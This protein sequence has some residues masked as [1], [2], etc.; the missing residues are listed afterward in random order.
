MSL[1]RSQNSKVPKFSNVS[2]SVSK[3]PE[4][5]KVKKVFSGTGSSQEFI[6]RSSSILFELKCNIQGVLPLN[7]M[8]LHLQ[9]KQSSEDYLCINQQL[10]VVRY[11][12]KNK[13]MEREIVFLFSSLYTLGI[14]SVF[15]GKCSDRF[16]WS[17]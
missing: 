11:C 17:M 13:C 6:S 15:L 9:G 16:K 12:W 3:V 2:Q 14:G 7:Q 1:L 10:V 4:V 5:P 8:P